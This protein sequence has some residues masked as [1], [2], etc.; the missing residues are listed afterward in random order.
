MRPY[1]TPH[2]SSGFHHECPGTWYV[3]DGGDS[4][5]LACTCKCHVAVICDVCNG[6]GTIKTDC[7]EWD[8]DPDNEKLCDGLHA[9]WKCG[10]KVKFRRES[11]EEICGGPAKAS[12]YEGE[13]AC[14][15][16]FGHEGEHVAMS[17]DANIAD[18]VCWSCRAK[19]GDKH[20]PRCY[21]EKK[22]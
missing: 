3:F 8:G 5:P 1:H 21:A 9:C 4:Q 17:R 7:N 20:W 2:C 18:G 6:T 14:L 16:A 11:D 15:R 12:F 19:P 10:P 13:C 22:S